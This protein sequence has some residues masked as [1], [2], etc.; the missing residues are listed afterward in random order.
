MFY[1]AGEKVAESNR[2][3]TPVKE[4]L[5]DLGLIRK[6]PEG[7]DEGPL[8][9]IVSVSRLTLSPAQEKEASDLQQMLSSENGMT[10]SKIS[11]DKG[12]L[13]F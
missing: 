2:I 11:S 9:P 12:T 13:D 3:S 5:A 8:I 1:I 6:S 4:G 7:S 10:P